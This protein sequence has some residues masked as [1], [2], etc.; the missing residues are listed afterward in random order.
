MKLVNPPVARM[1]QAG[2]PRLLAAGLH[3]P[4]L[5][6]GDR[7]RVALEAYPGLAMRRIALRAGLR[8]AP[9]YKN[10]APDK[11]TA[12]QRAAR[13]RLLGALVQGAYER[14]VQ[15]HVTASNVAAAIADGSGDTLD[16]LAAAAQAAW[17]ARHAAS[18]YGLPEHVDPL[19]GWIVTA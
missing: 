4:A 9:S 11:Q 8:R 10:D 1:L 14:G 12:A 18:N 15:M 17:G 16:A 7:T 19:E 13:E 3:V 2:A 5:H 6:E